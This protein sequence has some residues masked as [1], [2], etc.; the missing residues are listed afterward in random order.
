MPINRR[1]YLLLGGRGV[2]PGARCPG[3]RPSFGR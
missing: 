1:R 3:S 2:G